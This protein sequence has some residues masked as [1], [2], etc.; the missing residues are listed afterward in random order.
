MSL[1]IGITTLSSPI[2][3]FAVFSSWLSLDVAPVRLRI[4]TAPL[5]FD[6]SPAVHASLPVGN[7][8]VT[9]AEACFTQSRG[10]CPALPNHTQLRRLALLGALLPMS[11]LRID[12]C[13]REA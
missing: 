5:P 8:G 11:A 1:S 7:P 12:Q 4:L 9:P 10:L 6:S 13:F 2:R 3:G